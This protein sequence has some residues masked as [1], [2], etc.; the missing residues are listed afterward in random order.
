MD[1]VAQ[2]DRII[3]ETISKEYEKYSDD[4]KKNLH[5]LYHNYNKNPEK[6]NELIKKLEKVI[7]KKRPPTMAEFLTAEAGWLPRKVID[8]I[9]PH[10]KEDLLNIVDG[11]EKYFQISMYGSTR[12]GKSFMAQ[13]LM[14][15]TII[16]MHHLRTPAL[17]YG[18]SPLTKLCLYIVSFKF[19]K[20]REIYLKDIYNFLENS[21]RFVKIKFQDQV[22]E[23]QEEYGCDKIVWSKASVSGEITVASGLQILLGIFNIRA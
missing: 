2:K 21:D 8:S 9:W 3:E 20:S 15:Y 18:L 6:F 5:N 10:V 12:L 13:L 23:K 22:K 1:V 17:Y 11:N 4:E 7:F 19:D 16:F 14:I